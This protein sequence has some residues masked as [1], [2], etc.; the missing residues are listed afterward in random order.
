[1]RDD[2][3][4][5]HTFFP[6][7][8]VSTNGLFKVDLAY[9]DRTTGA[10]REVPGSRLMYACAVDNKLVVCRGRDSRRDFGSVG[11]AM[12]SIGISFDENLLI[13]FT[14][15]YFCEGIDKFKEIHSILR[16]RIESAACITFTQYEIRL[17]V[18]GITLGIITK[19]GITLH[20]GTPTY[21]E[22]GSVLYEIGFS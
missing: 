17:N 11:R 3:F 2:P 13:P 7:I 8:G 4:N 12:E 10:T 1:M 9:R 14:R 18:L 20:A 22:E 19:E 6:K 15:Q 5:Y 21:T 16:N